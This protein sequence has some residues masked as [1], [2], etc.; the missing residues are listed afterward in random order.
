MTGIRS[1]HLPTP[2]FPASKSS[3]C[4][5][6]FIC[7][8]NLV[9]IS[10]FLDFVPRQPPSEALRIHPPATRPG[11]KPAPCLR[12]VRAHS[13]GPP[14]PI[15]HDT[16][17]GKA[18]HPDSPPGLAPPITGSR[19]CPYRRFRLPDFRLPPAPLPRPKLLPG[20][21]ADSSRPLRKNPL[22]RPGAHVEHHH[23]IMFVHFPGMPLHI[24]GRSPHALFL[25][26]E[27]HEPDASAAASH[28]SALMAR[29]ASITIAAFAPLSSAPVPR[30]HE[31]RCAPKSTISS[32]CSRP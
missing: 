10:R 25:T 6:A 28:P 23:G 11:R 22:V 32:G 21:Y 29:A 1:C 27:Q 17:E 2:R 9:S 15:P 5:K 13:R 30:S 3:H 31:S 4:A 8:S 18:L 20:A 12:G 16:A 14:Y 7:A 24:S 19:N 26:G